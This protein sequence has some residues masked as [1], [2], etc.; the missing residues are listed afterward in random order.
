MLSTYRSSRTGATGY[1]GGS[2]L[3][4]LA[5]S[6]PEYAVTALVRDSAKGKIITGAFSKVEVVEGDL[7]DAETLTRE[8]SNADVVV[9]AYFESNPH[10]S[11]P[12]NTR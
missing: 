2:V 12:P 6:H 4:L 5:K 10:V 7:D 11:K 1:I 8:A 9:R 3:S